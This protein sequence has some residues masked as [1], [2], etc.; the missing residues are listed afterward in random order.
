M[1]NSSE[2]LMFVSVWKRK[3]FFI[4]VNIIVV[5]LFAIYSLAIYKPK[6]ESYFIIETQNIV[7]F[8][9]IISGNYKVKIGEKEYIKI[10]TIILFSPEEIKQI[11][12]SDDVLSWLDLKKREELR[13]KALFVEFISNNRFDDELTTLGKIKIIGTNS[14]EVYKTAQKVYQSFEKVFEKRCEEKLKKL[15]FDYSITYRKKIENFFNENLI[16]IYFKI[17]VTPSKPTEFTEDNRISIILAGIVIS[18][19]FSTLCCVFA[20]LL[21]RFI[22]IVK[23]I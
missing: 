18:I 12:Y 22:K 17:L 20:E 19:L 7:N 10:P 2:F 5:S 8:S 16:N 3:T 14:E 13:R 9:Q 15:M 21:S 23:T 1:Q 11:L 6:Y 4:I